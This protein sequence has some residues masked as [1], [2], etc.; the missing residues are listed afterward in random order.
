MIKA[1]IPTPKQLKEELQ[2]KRSSKVKAT[3]KDIET[4]RND[5]FRADG[6]YT[7][8]HKTKLYNEHSGEFCTLLEILSK[9]SKQ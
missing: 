4:V 1:D 2:S 6:D 5:R 8:S 7:E 9:H 3:L